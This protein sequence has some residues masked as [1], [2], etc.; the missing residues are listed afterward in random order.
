MSPL[1]E[2]E[3]RRRAELSW[4]ELGDITGAKNINLLICKK[5]FGRH[6]SKHQVS[7]SSSEYKIKLGAREAPARRPPELVTT[8]TA[9][10]NLRAVL[11]VCPL[12]F[13]R[14]SRASQLQSVSSNR[15][16]TGRSNSSVRDIQLET[17]P[18]LFLWVTN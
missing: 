3:E 4:G 15:S 6:S 5:L 1:E 12:E 16:G 7:D 17:S 11:G 8:Q 10:A 2:E 13:S 14:T 9:P 18:R